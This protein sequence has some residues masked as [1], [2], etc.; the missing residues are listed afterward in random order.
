MHSPK[1]CF[2]RTV[3]EFFWRL[4]E[5]GI[6]EDNALNAKD[7]SL[8]FK[9]LNQYR[10]NVH[11]MLTELLDEKFP[12]KTEMYSCEKLVTWITYCLSFAQVK[13][14]YGADLSGVG[15]CLRYQDLEHSVLPTR[16]LWRVVHVVKCFLK[17]R[18]V[19]QNEL[20]SLRCHDATL[21]MG[22]FFAKKHMKHLYEAESE[23]AQTRAQKYWAEVQRKKTIF[24]LIA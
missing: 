6:H 8:V 9:I 24:D 10:G 13:A 11:V 5:R 7:V 21:T 18:Y 3:E 17:E 1:S 2:F 15:V 4:A 12:R 20:F 19:R 23:A 14:T 22:Q 16:R